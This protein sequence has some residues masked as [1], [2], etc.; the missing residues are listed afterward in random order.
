MIALTTTH[1]TPAGS[2]NT[3]DTDQGTALR[4]AE[5]LFRD[6]RRWAD[7]HNVKASH[8]KL[9]RWVRGYRREVIAR[10]GRGPVLTLETYLRRTWA[11]PTGD[12]ATARA[13][14][15]GGDRP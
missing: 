5:S 1:N 8:S 13:D 9:S 6:A 3:G 14:R 2:T 7:A 4:S 12:K 10:A 15:R 11:D